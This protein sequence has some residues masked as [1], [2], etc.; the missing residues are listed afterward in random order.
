MHT[1]PIV[2]M[3]SVKIERE[4]GAAVSS[5]ERGSGSRTA[6]AASGATSTMSWLGVT[7][8]CQLPPVALLV[9][10]LLADA[11]GGLEDDVVEVGENFS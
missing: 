8:L 7:G 1:P 2:V 11:D 3:I 4:T 6:R 9:P 5:M 10:G